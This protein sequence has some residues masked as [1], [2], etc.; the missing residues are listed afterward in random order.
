MDE[1][2]YLAVRGFHLCRERRYRC[3]LLGLA[4]GSYFFGC[5]EDQRG[6]PLIFFGIIELSVGLYAVLFPFIVKAITPLYLALY[7]YDFSRLTI[8]FL[9]F[10]LTFVVLIVPTVLMGGTLPVVGK[11]FSGS[12]DR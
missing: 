7:D 11:F 1:A 2:A 5:L 8:F 6:N 3:F 4:A 12:F 10:L 9:R